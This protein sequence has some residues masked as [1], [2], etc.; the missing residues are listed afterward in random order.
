MLGQLQE[1]RA[2][3]RELQVLGDVTEKLRAPNAVRANGMISRLLLEELRE[4]A[5]V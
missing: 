5:G 1:Y 3:G 2:G 4:Q